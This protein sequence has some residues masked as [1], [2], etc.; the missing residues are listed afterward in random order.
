M[1]ELG[2]EFTTKYW[3]G[4]GGKFGHVLAYLITMLG[5]SEGMSTP[6]NFEITSGAFNVRRKYLS[7]SLSSK[8]RGGGESHAPHPQM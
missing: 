4:G 1:L 8:G 6:E 5:D 3:V 2:L 7:S